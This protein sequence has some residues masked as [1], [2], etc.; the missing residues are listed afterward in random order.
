MLPP[1][2]EFESLQRPR[3]LFEE[4]TCWYVL[5]KVSCLYVVQLLPILT[6]HVHVNLRTTKSLNPK[7]DFN[8]RSRTFNV[9]DNH[10]TDVFPF[11]LEGE[12]HGSSLH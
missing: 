1:V 4:E 9:N 7:P 11:S 10:G 8:H 12:S 3:K 6:L 2:E 5:T